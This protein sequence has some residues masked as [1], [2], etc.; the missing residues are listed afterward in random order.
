LQ[1]ELQRSSLV[2][3]KHNKQGNFRSDC[4]VNWNSNE[5][6]QLFL[7][8]VHLTYMWMNKIMYTLYCTKTMAARHDKLP[9][10]H[11]CSKTR[12]RTEGARQ[13]PFSPG[14]GVPAGRRQRK[15]YPKYYNKLADLAAFIVN[16]YIQQM[17]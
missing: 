8:A 10:V 7:R 13:H 3:E 2:Y 15:W 11:Y 5:G 1:F 16:E 17:V 6:D 9:L 14:L 4:T 12:R